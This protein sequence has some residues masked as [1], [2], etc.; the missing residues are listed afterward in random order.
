VIDLGLE[1]H[2]DDHITLEG[3]GTSLCPTTASGD[4]ATCRILTIVITL[5]KYYA[6]IP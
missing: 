3:D 6:N 5:K 1:K 4:D 2:G